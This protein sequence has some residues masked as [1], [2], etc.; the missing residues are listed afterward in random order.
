MKKPWVLKPK[1][2][3]WIYN[4]VIRP[5]I[6]YATIEWWL[7]VTYKTSRV[8]LSKLQKVVSLGISGA[9]RTAPATAT[10]VFLGLPPLH[11]KIEAETWAEP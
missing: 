4:V 2:L 10:G 8:D 1:E 9:E 11:L 7:R 3:Y 6:A 5:I